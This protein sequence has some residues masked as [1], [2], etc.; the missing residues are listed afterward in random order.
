VAEL[1]P[2]FERFQ[3]LDPD[4]AFGRVMPQVDDILDGIEGVFD[5]LEA[6]IEV[7]V[8]DGD[9]DALLARLAT[10]FE[11]FLV[12]AETR[13][14]HKVRTPQVPFG[15][16]PFLD[17]RLRSARFRVARHRHGE[18]CG[19]SAAAECGIGPVGAQQSGQLVKIGDSGA[20]PYD[21]WT[22]YRCDACGATWRYDDCS[23][24]QVTFAVWR[25][26]G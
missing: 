21:E 20:D 24:E 8:I 22:D 3:Q 16:G 4:A 12:R 10:V 7:A 14:G 25:R 2:W 5:R 9:A 6:S 26:L 18:P 19:C 15:I 23:T 11:E 17:Q 1:N 13:F